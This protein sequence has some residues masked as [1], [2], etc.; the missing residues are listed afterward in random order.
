M[1]PGYGH[2]FIAKNSGC[3]GYPARKGTLHT[4]SIQHSRALRWLR[5]SLVEQRSLRT[6]MRLLGWASALCQTGE[7]A[8]CNCHTRWTRWS[9]RR[10]A[11]A[12]LRASP[13][14]QVS[15][16]SLRLTS[17]LR[18]RLALKCQL[19]CSSTWIRRVRCRMLWFGA[20]LFAS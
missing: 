19:R 10:H 1:S 15:L 13:P 16:S 4:L 3:H 17:I 8:S 6:L 11:S 20:A 9:T 14:N 2:S 18:T 12:P 5:R 7:S